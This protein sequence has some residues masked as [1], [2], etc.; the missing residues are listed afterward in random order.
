MLG[1]LLRETDAGLNVLV[2]LK[3]LGASAHVNTAKGFDPMV[4]ICNSLQKHIV[5]NGYDIHLRRLMLV[6]CNFMCV[7]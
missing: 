2:R 3:C 6:Y 7:S 5:W 4:E 1:Q